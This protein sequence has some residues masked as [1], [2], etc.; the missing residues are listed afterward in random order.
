MHAKRVN[1]LYWGIILIHVL[2]PSTLLVLSYFFMVKVLQLI[3]PSNPRY[4]G[5]VL[6]MFGLGISI[7]TVLRGPSPY[8][9]AIRWYS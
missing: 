7:L 2:L 4:A 6:L 9:I 5:I 3:E 1:S 8:V